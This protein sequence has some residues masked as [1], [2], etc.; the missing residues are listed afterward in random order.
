MLLTARFSVADRAASRFP[1][2]GGWLLVF[3]AA[4]AAIVYPLFELARELV[5]AGS[6]SI[7]DTF[8][9]G[10]VWVPIFHTLWTSVV[11]TAVTLTLATA[12]ALATA[13]FSPRKRILV[14]VGMTLPFLIPPF[15]SA[16]SWVAA[17]GPGGLLD[18][19]FGLSLPGLIGSAGVVTLLVVNATPL[20]YLIVLSSLDARTERDLVRAARVSGATPLEALRTVTL[21]MLRP[22][23]IG[24]GAISFIMSANS[25]GVPAVLGTPAG[26]GTVTTRLYQDLVLSADP[27]AF[28][29]VLVLAAFLAAATIVIIGTAD[30]HSRGRIRLRV[31]PSGPRRGSSGGT[32]WS[33]WLI[34]AYVMATGLLP[35]V[36][37][38]LMSIT[39]G[40]GLSPV[41]TNWT[42]GN[43]EEVLDSGAVGAF[44]TS[45]MLAVTAATI[46]LGLGSLLVVLERRRRSGVGTAA[47]LS[48][49]VPGSVLAIGVLLA[50]GSV[51]RDTVLIILIAYIAKF[52]ALAHR[53]VAGSAD[54]VSPEVFGAA[55]LCGATP[56]T[57]ARTVVIPL[58]R[59]ALVTGWL[60]VFVFALHELTMSSLL[61]GPGNETLAVA[62]LNLQ[63]LGEPTVTSALAVLLTVG[64]ALAAIPLLLL[65]RTP[66]NAGRAR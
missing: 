4:A 8:A 48:F 11:A 31:E 23:L 35:F 36:A 7:A 52:W 17:Y 45:L 43:F 55:R 38:V 27:A 26:F 62:V 14:V 32:R 12:V 47:A 42:L 2:S 59:S 25:F 56:A 34:T 64:A 24:A 20:A 39:R 30:V 51:L 49:A 10:G 28:D 1:R 3:V 66:V 61:H 58:L 22:A 13:S 33:A 46:T 40:V 16:M 19:A 65:R 15:V 57:A 53:P 50:Y 63:Q 37:L 54:A 44:G 21:P 18:D 9:A 6:S 5:A 41:P 29:R 60:I